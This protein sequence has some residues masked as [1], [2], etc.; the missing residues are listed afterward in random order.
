MSN[1]L[2]RPIEVVQARVFSSTPETPAHEEAS[3][4]AES[5][6]EAPERKKSARSR[7]PLVKSLREL[8]DDDA[9]AI[10]LFEAEGGHTE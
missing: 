1:P 8:T 4:D 3:E 2:A 5:A 6:P 7:K 10:S 9:E